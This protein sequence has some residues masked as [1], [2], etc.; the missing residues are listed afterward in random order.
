MIDR[1]SNLFFC[2]LHTFGTLKRHMNTINT[3]VVDDFSDYFCTFAHENK[4][5]V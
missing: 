2:H 1:S 4:I 3:P 5:S